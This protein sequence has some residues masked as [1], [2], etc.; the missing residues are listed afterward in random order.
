MRV[1]NVP[2]A[3]I[4]SCGVALAGCAGYQAPA[5]LIGG[6]MSP[7]KSRTACVDAVARHYK[8]PA[9]SVKPLGDAST[10]KD[11]IYVVTLSAV[12]QPNV[13]C[14]VDENGAVTDVIRAR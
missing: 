11:G 13:N 12:G 5:P 10:M 3:A 14:T 1:R 2:L 8:V 7:Q 6:F 9:D 4:L